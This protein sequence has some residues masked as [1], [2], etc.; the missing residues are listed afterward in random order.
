MIVSSEITLRNYMQEFF[1]HHLLDKQ[2]GKGGECLF[3]P[4]EKR[5]IEHIVNKADN[6]RYG[7]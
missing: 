2:K 7:R 1:D 6:L 5:T 3:V 4:C